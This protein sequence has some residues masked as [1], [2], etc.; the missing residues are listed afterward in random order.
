MA[1]QDTSLPTGEALAGLSAEEKRALLKR[2]LADR[3][4]TARTPA[5]SEDRY[6]LSFAQQRLWFIEQLAPA[7]GAYAIPAAVALEGPLDTG[8]LVRSLEAV[9]ERHEILRTRF[10]VDA[11]QTPMQVVDP[12]AP[13]DLPVERFDEAA[14]SDPAEPVAV[15]LSAMTSEPFDLARGPLLRMR[16]LRMNR[17]RYVLLICI[18]HAIADYWSLRVLM[19]EIASLYR[20]GRE[21]GPGQ[22]APLPIQYLDYA[23]WQR[24]EQPRLDAEL[25]HWREALR[26]MPGLLALPTDFARPPRLSFRGARHALVLPAGL[27]TRLRALAKAQRASLFAVLLA[28]LQVLL[29]RLSGQADFGIGT[30]ATNRNRDELRDLIGLFANN[31]VLR[32]RLS[33][34]QPFEHV[35]Q[36]AQRTTLSALAHQDVPFERVVEAL[37]PERELSHNALFQVMFVLHNTAAQSIELPDLKLTALPI[38]H[39]S[40]RFDLSLDLVDD[41]DALHGFIEYRTDLFKAASIE[42]IAG[43]LERILHA[44]C[45]SPEM[46]IGQFDLV[47][48][49]D[50]EALERLDVTALPLPATTV[51]AFLEAQAWR[52]PDA[53]AVVAGGQRL[54]YRELDASANELACHL[55]REGARAGSAVALAMPRG[56]PMLCSLLAVLKLGGHYVP[57]DPTHPPSRLG[58]LLADAGASILLGPPAVTAALAAAAPG[59]RPIDIDQAMGKPTALEAAPPATTV[60]EHGLAYL[61]H[62]SGSTGAPKGVPV[63]HGSLVNLLASV[64]RVPGIAPGD[65]LLAVTTLAFD[66]ATLELL[67]PLAAGASVVIADEATGADGAALAALIAAERITIMQAT[68]AT[69]RLL[70]EAGWRAPSG[71]KSLCGGEAIDLPLARALKAAGC[72][73]WNMYGP[74][75]ATIWAGALELT[76]ERLADGIVPIGGPIANTA[77]Q[78]CEA[79]GRAAPVGV[80]GELTISGAGLSPGYHGLDALTRE[81]FVEST[82]AD[83]RVTRRYRTG[84]LACRRTDGTFVFHGRAD[85]QVKLRG[86]RIELGEIESVL[87]LHP[88]VGAAAVILDGTGGGRLQAWCETRADLS[89][90]A[91]RAHVAERLP[92]Y[93]VPAEFV[94][95]P[96]LPLTPNGKLDRSVLPQGGGDS[97][98]ARAPDGPIECLLAEL[99]SELLQKPV[100]D[101]T[102]SFFAIGGHSLLAARM[103]ARLAAETGVALALRQIFENPVLCELASVLEAE[104]AEPTRAAAEPDLLPRPEDALPVLTAAQYRQWVLARLE[105]DNPVYNI[106]GVVRFAAGVDEDR[107]RAAVAAVFER[108]AVLRTAYPEVDGEPQVVVHPSIQPVI[109]VVEPSEGVPTDDA[110]LSTLAARARDPFDLASAP[111]MRVALLRGGDAGDVV[112]LVVHHIACDA[113][114]L[115]TLFGE[116]LA[117]YTALARGGLATLPPLKLAYLDHAHAEVQRDFGPSLDYWRAQLDGAP[118]LLD[119][120]TDL[121]RPAEQGFAAGELRFAIDNAL[122]SRLTA[123]SEQRGASLFMTVL[124]AFNALLHRF[125]AADDIVVGC[126]VGHRPSTALE[127]VIGL[128]VNTLAIRSRPQAGQTFAAFLEQVRET[129]LDGFAHQDAPFEQVVKHLEIPRSWA[130][131]PLFQ[132]MFLWQSDAVQSSEAEERSAE[133]EPLALPV[134]S[135]RVDLTL[136][137]GAAVDG[138]LAGRFEYRSDLF[139][140]GSIEGLADAF[141]VLL[142]AVAHAPDTAIG[143]LRLLSSAGQA[144]LERWNDTTRAGD[145]AQLLHARFETQAASRPS[146]VALVTRDEEVTYGDLNAQANALAAALRDRGIGAGG[147]VGVCLARGPRLPAS[148]LGILKTGAAYVPIDPTYPEERIRFII[149]DAMLAVVLSEAEAIR[150]QGL[151]AGGV[152]VLDVATLAAGVYDDPTPEATPK[153][154]AYIIYTSG[155]TGRPKG[156][157]I[158]HRSPAA[159]IDWADAEFGRERLDRVLASTSVCFDL[160]VFELFVPLSIGGTVVLVENA[161]A[162]P[163]LLASSQVT[164]INTVPTVASELV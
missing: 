46:S 6:P 10:V 145:D 154:T 71:F 112:M 39:E 44:A 122:A 20:A 80:L 24:G 120:P 32:A 62:T 9:L 96:R 159:L 14:G 137:M 87:S 17:Q 48:A 83:G 82:D 84:D 89:A 16:L 76:D 35:L 21:D 147:R 38:D 57:L 1:A 58:D 119:L 117:H 7:Q 54:S 63:T 22:L 3:Q 105:P 163:Q 103:V 69:W 90:A 98:P 92:A 42:R 36:E 74:T 156:V 126:P 109:D 158:E 55:L 26:G 25:E 149:E 106:P 41:G 27:S 31:L 115:R 52:T 146:A 73:L 111:L 124:A 88:Q 123:L 50:R 40:S 51:S 152:S 81:R 130:H 77:L 29:F 150:R 144:R 12:A 65:R 78:V 75:E 113:W 142:R 155:S 164:L 160:S 151:G 45:A 33:R 97:A 121:P 136:A 118:P 93:M 125:S 148:I 72:E 133:W 139:E 49:E 99:W 56:V 30:T 108:H 60:D 37:Q 135:T 61:I 68:P 11:R 79:D 13:I 131:A 107:L 104:R 64:I 67:A 128:F 4:A 157:A 101:A 2:L 138:G 19:R 70:L 53:E 23:V 141:E 47:S 59:C 143:E 153:D 85:R 140:R 28:A 86:Y 18:H 91:L 134:T 43:Y 100:R 8:R 66:I 94:T 162:D 102:V 129:V 114:S 15:A 34:D 116:L 127:G 5:T 161:L 132:V 95:L 110:L